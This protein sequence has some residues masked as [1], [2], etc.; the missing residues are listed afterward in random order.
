MTDYQDRK[1]IDNLYDIVYDKETD[2]LNLTK[3]EDFDGFKNEVDEDYLK[4]GDA[5]AQYSLLGHIH[6]YTTETQVADMIDEAIGEQAQ[7]DLQSYLKKE[8]ALTTYETINNVSSH[9]GNTTDAHDVASRLTTA[10]NTAKSYADGKVSTHNADSSAH[11]GIIS[12]VSSHTSNTTD[13]HDVANRLASNLATAK[14]YADGGD[15]S[16]LSSAK[17]YADTG[18]SS[19]LSS[20]KTYSDG[21]LSTHTSDSTAHGINNKANAIHTHS[22][23]DITDIG[24]TPVTSVTNGSL[25]VNTALQLASYTY[26]LT[27]TPF[28]S[29]TTKTLNN[30][31]AIIPSTYRP[32][33]I[34]FCLTRGSLASMSIAY[35]NTDGTVTMVA[36]STSSTSRTYRIYF[37]WKYG[38]STATPTSISLASNKSAISYWDDET[39]TFTATALDTDSNPCP[40][41]PVTFKKGS[42]VLDTQD[43]DS[44]G[45]ATYTYTA[46][47]DGDVTITAEYS[48]LSDTETIEDCYFYSS[49]E[50]TVTRDTGNYYNLDYNLIFNDY[51]SNYTLSVDM[52]TTGATSGNEHRLYF[53]TM[54]AFVESMNQNKQPDPSIYVGFD[55]NYAQAGT[56]TTSSSNSNKSVS[57]LTN[58]YHTFEVAKSGSSYSFYVDDGL[59]ATKSFSNLDNANELMFLVV[60]WSSG[61]LNVKNI[62]IK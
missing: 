57:N 4:K 42:T 17:S 27:G 59:I 43:T 45:Q 48:S 40:N 30:G 10:I 16:T 56:R 34:L 52:K 47:G 8:D 31:N 21:K 13:A 26:E 60:L 23:T 25:K 62:K 50:Y 41:I 2:E 3:K 53:T 35:L 58:T 55:N 7:V 54:D 46:N 38:E 49:Q 44:N 19:T 20:A 51:P 12:T 11:N 29:D 32:S 22:S 1:D 6:D 39:C 33:T 5:I 18:D 61:T 24:W 36:Q 14:S 28:S 37:L 15:T 9:T